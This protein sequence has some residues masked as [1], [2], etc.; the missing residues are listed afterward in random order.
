MVSS[1]SPVWFI[2]GCS[3]G[4]GRA[5]AESVLER[6][7]RAAVTARDPAALAGLVERYPQTALALALD[8]TS[9][10]AVAAAVTQTMSRFGRIDVLVNNAGYGYMAVIEEGEEDAIQAQFDANFFGLARVTRAVLPHMRAQRSGHV[11]NITSIRGFEAK[12]GSGYYA[13]TKFAVEG[14]TEALR[15]EVAGFGIKVTAVE[16]GSFR[17]DWSG[18]SLKATA[19]PVRDYP[20]SAAVR[21]SEMH[22]RTG[23]QLGD[24]ARAAQAL[25]TLTQ[26]ANPP[27]HLVLGSDALASARA[28]IAALGKELDDWA[29][30]SASTDFPS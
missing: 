5:L 30:L 28:K 17:T 15:S 12:A 10:A 3:T 13:A 21:V 2:T 29:E 27:G 1:P 26:A 8:V 6:G 16:P 4:I 23:R 7:W 25:I 19:H 11:I 24:P 22:Q 18:R 14:L 20:H 9:P